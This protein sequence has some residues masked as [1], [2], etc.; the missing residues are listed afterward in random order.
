MGKEGNPNMSSEYLQGIKPILD[1]V[2]HGELYLWKKNLFLSQQFHHSLLRKKVII[3]SSST[4]YH[5]RHHH[6]HILSTVLIHTIPVHHHPIEATKK[7]LWQKPTSRNVTGVWGF[8]PS[9]TPLPSSNHPFIINSYYWLSSSKYGHAISHAIH[10]AREYPSISHPNQIP[11]SIVTKKG[12][13]L[14]Y[15]PKTGRWSQP[16]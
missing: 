5:H 2:G 3:R 12:K 7:A 10:N 13:S 8:V 4:D 9:A 11:I 14:F 16:L 15:Y 6:N 1:H